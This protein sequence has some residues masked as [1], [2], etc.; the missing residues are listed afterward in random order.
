M[1][2]RDSGGGGIQLAHDLALIH[3]EDA[4]GQAHD[5]VQ[6]QRD[7]Q[8]RLALVPL[9]HQLAVDVLNGAHVQA[10][11]EMCIRDSAKTATNWSNVNV[12]II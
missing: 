12:N 11:G 4:V 6:L 3:H 8:H 9:G 1:C 5:L 7:Q 10:A 2:I